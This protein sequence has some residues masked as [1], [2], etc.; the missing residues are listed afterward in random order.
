MGAISADH[1][2]DVSERA[3][4]QETTRSSLRQMRTTRSRASQIPSTES[5]R[6]HS[7]SGTGIGQ[8]SQ[9][10]A[11]LR[12]NDLPGPGISRCEPL[13]MSHPRNSRRA[14]ASPSRRTV[15]DAEFDTTVSN[16]PMQP[17]SATIDKSFLTLGF[18]S[19]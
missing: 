8:T 14:A 2:L 5:T 12:L 7:P 10:P 16:S 3:M 15:D 19:T 1:A 13:D 11:V 4:Y 9:N 17:A 18:A 6:C